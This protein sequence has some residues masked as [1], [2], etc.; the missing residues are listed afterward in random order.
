M[1]NRYTIDNRIFKIAIYIRLSREDG[2][3]M[4]SESVTNQRSLLIGYL[5]AQN[6]VAVDIYIDDG[7]TGTNFERP[8]FKRMLNDIEKGKIN[9]VITKDLSRLGRDHIMTGYYVETYFPENDVRYIAVNDD[10]DTFYETSGSDMMPFKLSMNDM[11]A[12]DISKKVRSNLLQMKKDGKFCGSSAPYGYMRDPNNKHQLIPDPNSAPVVKRIFDLYVAGYGSSGIAEI[13]TREELPT[14]IMF[15]YSGSKLNKFD[16]PEIWKHTSISNIIKNRVYIGDLIQHKFQ[17]VNYKIKKR[18]SVPENEW[19][20][21]ENAHEAIIDKKTFEIAQ[22][23]KDSSNT[24][25]PERRN[26][27]YVLSDLV[28]CKDCGARM[29]I[30]YDKKRDRITM[31]CN[32]YRKFS[33]YNICFSHYINY[34]KLEKTVYD[35]L[36]N[37]ANK[38]IED[39]EEFESII[40]SEYIDPRQDK[41]KK[42]EELNYKIEDLKRKQDSLYDDKFNNIISVET[43]TRLFNITEDEIKTANEKLEILKNEISS[44]EEDSNC[45]VEY[46]E[47]INK[48]LN[49]E[50]PTKE[51]MNKLKYIELQVKFAI[52][53]KTFFEQD[54]ELD[55]KNYFYYVNKENFKFLKSILNIFNDD[56]LKFLTTYF[57]SNLSL[58]EKLSKLGIKKRR[59]YY[60]TYDKLINKV[61]KEVKENGI[62]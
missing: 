51:I 16:H 20:I 22:S 34:T 40:K 5:K 31:N 26:V 42:I 53:L 58:T 25:N 13:L 30:S 59:K 14:P 37:M 38:Y 23:I 57:N 47:I 17:K 35:K 52:Q 15:K 61:L 29:S 55:K 6:L 45:Y 27:E 18:K 28:Y 8:D 4:E 62:L 1:Y 9:M 46:L 24:Y 56:E 12:K 48:F 10:I 7:Y 32:N 33:K 60:Y 41:L 21:K 49:M 2:D 3:D 36:S 19:C 44:I 11:Y 39:K 54:I 43:Y 50:N